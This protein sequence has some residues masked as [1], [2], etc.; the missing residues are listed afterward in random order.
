MKRVIRPEGWIIAIEE[1][2]GVE[3]EIVTGGIIDNRIPKNDPKDI[4]SIFLELGLNRYQIKNIPDYTYVFQKPLKS[5]A[6]A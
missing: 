2:I 1:K 6:K 4:S 3:Y 5:S